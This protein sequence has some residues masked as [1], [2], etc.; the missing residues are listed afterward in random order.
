MSIYKRGRVYYYHFIFNGQHVQESTKQGNPNRA[1][2]MEA[3]HRARLAREAHE[4]EEKAEQLG[5]AVAQLVRCAEC[6]KL[7]NGDYAVLTNKGQTVCSTDCLRLWEKRQAPVPTLKQFCEQRVKTWLKAKFEHASPKTWQ[8]YQFG[9]KTITAHGPLADKRIDAISSEHIAGFAA[10]LQSEEWETASIN[11]ALRA[12]RRVLRLAAEWGVI[13]TAPKVGLLRGEHHREH[14]V[15]PDEETKYLAAAVIEPLASIAPVLMDTGLRPDECFRLRWENIS[16]D[17]GRFGMLRVTHG[18]TAAARRVLPLSPRV[19]FVL[20]SRWESAGKPIEGW[21][22]PAPTKSGHVEHDSVR[23]Q[24]RKALT[25]SKVRPFVL[26]SLRHTFLTRLGQSGCDVWTL[27][28]IAG[29]SSITM[30]AR[31]V[32]PSGDAVLSA[33]ARLEAQAQPQQQEP[34]EQQTEQRQLTQ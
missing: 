14:V 34:T 13:A 24:H 25:A 18:K 27:M 9:L 19:R 2:Q 29:H 31:Y 16:F 5:C 1:R 33:M 3:D 8:W 6:D 21:V 26:Y 11:A 10:H 23:V 28:R 7:F 20:E 12:L 32:H 17:T 4:R 30:S 22:W 15:T